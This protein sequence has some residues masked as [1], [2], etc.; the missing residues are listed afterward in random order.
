VTAVP[1]KHSRYSFG[2]TAKVDSES[3]NLVDNL[4]RTIFENL[5]K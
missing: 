2:P 4:W 5:A 1:N 3:D